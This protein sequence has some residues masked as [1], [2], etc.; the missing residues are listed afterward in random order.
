MKNILLILCVLSFVSCAEKPLDV[1][2]A[3]KVVEL[4]I[5]KSDKQEWDA[6]GELYTAEFNSSEPV[7]IK[8]QKL[9][10]LRDTLG[11]VKSIELISATNVA[12]FGRPQQVVLKYRVVHSRITSIETFTV[13]EDEEGYKISTHHVET[14]TGI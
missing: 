7:E 3:K 12:E 10:R 6:V 1:E 9:A 8:K 11:P 5:E 4:L 14:E 13:Q 2:T